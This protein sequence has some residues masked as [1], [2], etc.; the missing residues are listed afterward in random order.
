MAVFRKRVLDAVSSTV[1]YAGDSCPLPPDGRFV[2]FAA[3][4]SRLD[5]LAALS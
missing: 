4:S 2:P 3:L 1:V 5:E